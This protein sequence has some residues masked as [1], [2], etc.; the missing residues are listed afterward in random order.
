M[1]N[2]LQ[3]IEGPVRCLILWPVHTWFLF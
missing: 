3:I 1:A 2:S